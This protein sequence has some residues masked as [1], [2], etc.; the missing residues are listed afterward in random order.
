MSKIIKQLEMD[1]LSQTFKNVR[2]LVVLS[3]AGVNAQNDN[4]T[5]LRLR[6]KSIRLQVVK[7]SLTRRVFESMGMKVTSPEY[8]TGPTTLAWGG[9][10]LSELSRELETLFKKNE[11]IKFK[12][13]ISDGQEVSFKQALAMPTRAEAIG[14]VIGLAMAPAARL[15]G[16]IL[17]PG[18]HLAGQIKSVSER[19]VPAEAG[20]EAAATAAPTT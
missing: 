8:W 17:G 7:N 18:S 1:S 2:D 10:S 5:R 6:K 16:Q 15:L 9:S 4:Q 13:A 11:K 12:G 20:A 19:T 3:G 14:R